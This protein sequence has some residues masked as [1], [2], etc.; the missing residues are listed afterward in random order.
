MSTV[1]MLM[2]IAVQFDFLVHHMDVKT[3]YLNAPIER[4]LYMT[5]PPGYEQSQG[6]VKLVCKLRKSIYGL[7]Q[8]GRN[9]NLLLHNFLL[10]KGFQQSKHDACLYTYSDSP[11]VAIIL[12]WVDDILTTA[13]SSTC[14]KKIKQHLIA[15]FRMKDLGPISCFLGIRFTRAEGIITMDQSEYLRDKLVKFKMDNCKPRTTP[16]ELAGYKDDNNTPYENITLYREMV[17][18]LIYATTCTRPDLSWVVSKLSQHLSNPTEID[19]T[20]LKHVFRY[21]SGTVDDRLKFKKSRNG[22]KLQAY[23]DSDWAS[24][25]GRRSTTGYY[26]SLSPV[27]PALSWK[28]KKQ[29]TVPLSS[30]EAEYMALCAT[31]KE[32]IFLSNVLNDISTVVKMP[33]EHRPVPVHVD[34]QGAI[35]LAKNPVHHERSKHIDILYHFSRECVAQEKIVIYY[36]PSADN[37]SDVMTKAVSK[38]KLSKFRKALFG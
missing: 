23:S 20:M 18:S 9:W 31:S 13:N 27:G 5:Q 14:L 16:C 34:N 26:F 24:S 3:A 36:I 25:A 2:Q 10:E 4:E 32:A 1:R 37:V 12:I 7:K 22:L 11:D 35:A 19:F 33:G 8:S 15:K 28:S 6:N 17:G 29:Q 30:C 38:L 21:I